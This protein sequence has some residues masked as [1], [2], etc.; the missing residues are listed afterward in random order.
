[1]SIEARKGIEPTRFFERVRFLP[2]PFWIGFLLVFIINAAQWGYILWK[3]PPIEGVVFLHYT[4]Y[5][6]VDITGQ[7][8]NIL[9]IPGAGLLF[10]VLNTLVVFWSYF[11]YPLIAWVSVVFSGIMNALI[12]LGLYFIIHVNA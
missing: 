3:F 7:W 6:G 8:W 9:L 12:L 4:I 5:F 11:R 2:A 1:M 10:F